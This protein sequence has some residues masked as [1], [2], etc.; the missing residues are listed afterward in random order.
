MKKFSKFYYRQTNEFV[1]TFSMSRNQDITQ[2]G[3]EF[4]HK[5]GEAQLQMH[6]DQSAIKRIN[7][8]IPPLASKRSKYKFNFWSEIAI[9]VKKI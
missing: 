4:A 2:L 1:L 8:S 7:V 6:K 3:G 9:L 5:E